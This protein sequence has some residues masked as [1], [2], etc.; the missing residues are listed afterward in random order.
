MGK[1]EGGIEARSGGGESDSLGSHEACHVD[2]SPEE[3]CSG[4]AEAMGKAESG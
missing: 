4:T 3:D 1:G 2:F